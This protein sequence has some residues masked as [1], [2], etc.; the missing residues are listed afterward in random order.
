MG[1]AMK[2]PVPDPVKL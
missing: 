1:A 2:H